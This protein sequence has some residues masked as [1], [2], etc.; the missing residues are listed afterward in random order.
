MLWEMQNLFLTLAVHYDNMC[1]TFPIAGRT[2]RGRTDG[3]SIQKTKPFEAHLV[4]EA[5]HFSIPNK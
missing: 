2:F 3:V 5:H 1:H 4:S